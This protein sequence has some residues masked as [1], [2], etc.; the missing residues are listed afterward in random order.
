MHSSDYI[1]FMN[2]NIISE[3][4][5]W[6]WRFKTPW[7]LKPKAT[8]LRGVTSTCMLKCET[9]IQF[10]LQVAIYLNIDSLGKKVVDLKQSL[11]VERGFQRHISGRYHPE[12]KGLPSWSA[13]QQQWSQQPKWVA[14]WL[15]Q[16]IAHFTADQ[17]LN[18][19]CQCQRKQY[20]RFVS[21]NSLLCAA[22][23]INC[24]KL[25]CVTKDYA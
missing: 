10:Y 8:F 1:T 25:S 23:I 5:N 4:N 6:L 9:F 14:T 13:T 19:R 12:A 17:D 21:Y 3:V 2:G 16:R 20:L 18:G 7:L 11:I 24:G 15:R 22:S